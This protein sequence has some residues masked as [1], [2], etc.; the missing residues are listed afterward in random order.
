MV[1]YPVGAGVCAQVLQAILY[2]YDNMINKID[3]YNP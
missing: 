2:E 3:R 1:V